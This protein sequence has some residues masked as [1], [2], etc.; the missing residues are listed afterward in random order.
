MQPRGPDKSSFTYVTRSQPHLDHSTFM[1]YRVN[2]MIAI[3]TIQSTTTINTV[4][5]PSHSI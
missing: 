4:A 3:Q 5:Q 2:H 1:L